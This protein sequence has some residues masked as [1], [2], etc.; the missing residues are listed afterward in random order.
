MEHDILVITHPFQHYKDHVLEYPD[1]TALPGGTFSKPTG[2]AADDAVEQMRDILRVV[3]FPNAFTHGWNNPLLKIWDEIYNPQTLSDRYAAALTF[4]ADHGLPIIVER[5]KPYDKLL[6]PELQ[7]LRRAH[8]AG[9]ITPTLEQGRAI[10]LEG[11]LDERTAIYV[12][13]DTKHDAANAY[14]RL[15][16]AYGVRHASLLPMFCGED[17]EETQEFLA[18]FNQDHKMNLSCR[19]ACKKLEF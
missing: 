1:R 9:I 13:G 11:L 8:A 7:F 3:N 18:K 12:V 2:R 6:P 19:T 4:A 15:H 10:P 14:R 16:K 5:A 17:C